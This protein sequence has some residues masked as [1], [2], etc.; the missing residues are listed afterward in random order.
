MKSILICILAISSV[1]SL[2]GFFREEY[3]ADTR[4]SVFESRERAWQGLRETEKRQREEA[5]RLRIATMK[6]D[7]QAKQM[8]E[9]KK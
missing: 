5:A 8:Q 9:K 7:T 3:V 6:N 1:S 4:P 2:M